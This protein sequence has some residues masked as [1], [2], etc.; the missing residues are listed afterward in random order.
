MCVV[1]M[2]IPISSNRKY[3]YEKGDYNQFN[4]ELIDLD[5]NAMFNGLTT[6]EM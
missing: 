5:W 2:D 6:E 1:C 4:K 3:S